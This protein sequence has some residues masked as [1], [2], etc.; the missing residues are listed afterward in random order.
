MWWALRSLWLKWHGA[1][2]GPDCWRPGWEGAQTPA[3]LRATTPS[4]A[5]GYNLACEDQKLAKSLLHTDDIYLLGTGEL[6]QVAQE[7]MVKLIEGSYK[8][9]HQYQ[10]VIWSTTLITLM[11]TGVPVILLDTAGG[12]R[13][14]D[15]NRCQGSEGSG[16]T[17]GIGPDP[18][19]GLRPIFDRRWLWWTPIGLEV[20]WCCSYSVT[21]SL[22]C[23]ACLWTSPA[24][25]PRVWRWSKF[26]P[27]AEIS[28]I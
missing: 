2:A 20:W 8:H 7:G 26:Q 1:I 10:P 18:D 4:W 11:E 17:I 3:C 23:S 12:D 27:S 28:S 13:Q 22:R 21:I 16:H 5:V 14:S 6:L 9:A 19:E 25:S 15:T 24:T